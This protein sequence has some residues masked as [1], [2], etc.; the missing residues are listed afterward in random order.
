MEQQ[1]QENA[2][3]ARR[4]AQEQMKVV[5][6]YDEAGVRWLDRYVEG[7]RLAA[8][9]DTK[10]KLPN[11]LGSFLGECIRQTYG[12]QWIQ[13]PELGWAIRV[14]NKLTVSPFNKVRK[15][16]ANVDGDSVLGLFTSISAMLSSRKASEAS[17]VEALVLPNH[18]WWKFW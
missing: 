6:D 13:D 16:L 2:E 12:G 10:A 18:P 1:I 9:E 8:S 15:H 11:T 3:L 5:V 4:V 14:N 17:S 7:Q